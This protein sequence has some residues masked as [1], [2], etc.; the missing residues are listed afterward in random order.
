MATVHRKRTGNETGLDYF[1][2]RYYSS[3]QGRFTSCDEFKGDPAELFVLGS[4]D[5]EKQAHMAVISISDQ[6]E[7][8]WKVAGWAFRQV[9]DDVVTHY[10]EDVEMAEK[11]EQS[12]ALSGLHLDLL[13]PEFAA[14]IA[15]AI[16]EVHNRNS[17]GNSAIGH[18][19]ST[20]RR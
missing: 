9:L 4:G 8:I 1:H 11:F 6:P 18:R 2:A 7:D 20:L 13:H 17:V 16:L 19:G 3:V 5:P 14:R 15:K 12:K 10:P